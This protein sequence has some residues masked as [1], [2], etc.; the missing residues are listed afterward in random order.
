MTCLPQGKPK[1]GQSRKI[2][3]AAATI[4]TKPATWF[5]FSGSPRYQTEKPANTSRV[6]LEAQDAYWNRAKAEEKGA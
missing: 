5:H 4:S 2:R 3:N 6:P 1:T